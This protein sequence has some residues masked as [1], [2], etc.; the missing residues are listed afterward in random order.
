MKL[1]RRRQGGGAAPV[2][3]RFIDLFMLIV[4]ALVFI[5][6]VSIVV[7]APPKPSE[8]LVVLTRTLPLALQ[9]EPYEIYFAGRG[10]QPPYGWDIVSGELPDGL[11]LDREHGRISG[12]PASQGT[13]QF[14]AE[15]RDA[16]NDSSRASLRLEV[17]ATAR[18]EPLHIAGPAAALPEAVTFVPYHQRLVATGGRPPYTFSMNAVHLPPGL[19]LTGTGILGGEPL[20]ARGDARLS[21]PWHF[22]VAA[23][24]AD[25]AETRQRFV[26]PVRYEPRRSAGNR[27]GRA[28]GMIFGFA[29]RYVLVPLLAVSLATVMLI[30]ATGFRGG[31]TERWDGMRWRRS[32]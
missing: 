14:E 2:E 7:S 30:G 8:P 26:L 18:G 9:D 4:A 3:L 20:V 15:L 16:M 31:Q 5:A 11:Q 22:T 24:D 17:R 10:G 25:G 27:A 29:F 28:V 12:R 32:R 19:K 6:L 23:I 13:T 1:R 21:E